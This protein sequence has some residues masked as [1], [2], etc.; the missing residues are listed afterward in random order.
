M[1]FDVAARAHD[2][3]ADLDPFYFEVRRRRIL[4]TARV[5]RARAEPPRLWASARSWN[6]TALATYDRQDSRLHLAAPFARPPNF[7]PHR[8]ACL[9]PLA[10]TYCRFPLRDFR[11]DGACESMESLRRG[12][13]EEKSSRRTKK[14]TPRRIRARRP[15]GASLPTRRVRRNDVNK[16]RDSC[17]QHLRPEPLMGP[18]PVAHTSP[19][20]ALRHSASA[21]VS[22][23][24][25]R[26]PC[27]PPQFP[28]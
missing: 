1:D 17:P 6:R 27:P 21:P 26:R 13:R 20:R 22:Q 16:A 11:G 12:G 2:L 25:N 10:N 24:Y 4:K 3:R 15:V 23:P 14:M 7:P 8:A 9:G 19:R 5:S 18:R 28:K